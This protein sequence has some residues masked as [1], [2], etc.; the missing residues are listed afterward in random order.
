MFQNCC[1]CFA[2]VAS[3]V[4]KCVAVAVAAVDKCTQGKDPAHKEHAGKDVTP[5]MQQTSSQ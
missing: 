5:E 4:I 1:C 3:V 2:V